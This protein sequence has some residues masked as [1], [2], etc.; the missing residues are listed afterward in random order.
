MRIHEHRLGQLFVCCHLTTFCVAHTP[1]ELVQAEAQDLRGAADCT[2]W[3][4]RS[5]EYFG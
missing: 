4:H 1:S 2:A 5:N 3:Q